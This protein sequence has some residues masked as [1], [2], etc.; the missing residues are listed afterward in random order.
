MPELDENEY[1]EFQRLKAVVGKVRQNPA[2]LRK[3]Q[4]A[5]ADAVPEEVGPEIRI[6][7][8]MTEKIGGIEKTL[9]DFVAEQRKER[10]ERQSEET[11]RELEGR[12][13]KGRAAARK[14]GYMDEG[15]DKLEAYMEEKGVAD[16]EIAI[17]AFE[18]L[19]P[20]PE[21]VVSGNSRFNFFDQPPQDMGLDLLM[22]GDDEGFLRKAIPS[23][24][25]EARGQ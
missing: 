13:L 3:M 7:Q 6:R 2:A 12:W 4:E 22:K 5:I 24:L 23:A 16:H 19:N 11:K 9:A 25:K 17:P 20:P 15:L 14:A 1:A 18:K 8:E 21:P 10:E